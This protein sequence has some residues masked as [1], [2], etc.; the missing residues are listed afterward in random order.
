MAFQPYRNTVQRPQTPAL[1]AMLQGR[2]FYLPNPMDLQ[3]QA[4]KQAGL[5]RFL[6]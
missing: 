4:A 1:L 2:P 5:L 6:R 3:R